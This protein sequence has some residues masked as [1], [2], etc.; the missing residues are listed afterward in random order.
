MYIRVLF[1][2]WR[3]SSSPYSYRYDLEIEEKREE[4]AV[5]GQCESSDD[6]SKGILLESTD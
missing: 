2:L 4:S 1:L 5:P 6:N 3:T